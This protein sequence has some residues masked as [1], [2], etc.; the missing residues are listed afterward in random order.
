M[1]ERL[2]LY[3]ALLSHR[4]RLPVRSVVILGRPAADGPGLRGT[5]EHHDVLDAGSGPRLA[6]RYDVLRL[7][8]HPVQDLRA[9]NLATLPL[10]PLSDLGADAPAAVIR[11]M[12][13]RIRRDAPIEQQQ[14]LWTA[15]YLLLGLR[16]N[17]R[18]AA[19]LLSGVR[20]MRESTTYQAILEEGR[21]E[22]RSEGL[23]QGL[24]EG[25]SRGRVQGARLMLLRLGAQKFGLPSPGVA[26]QINVIEDL[27]RLEA[28]GDRVLQVTSWDELLA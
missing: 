15:T 13:E 25:E 5:I 3:Y 8:Q 20:D 18:E 19:E 6:L 4:H 11:R 12:G 23:S 24:S 27:A 28:L 9:G 1:P 10:A 2:L 21:S 16:Y 14:T 7:W 17:S 22:G 26:A